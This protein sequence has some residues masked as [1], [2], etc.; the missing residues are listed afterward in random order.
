VSAADWLTVARLALAASLWPLALS[1]HVQAA[2]VGLLLAGFTDAL[3]GRLARRCG[4]ASRR[5]A[6][7]DALADAAVM[8]SVAALLAFLHPALLRDAGALIGLTA[9]VYLI[10]TVMSWIVSR[11]LVDPA[12]LSGKL[13]GGMLYV[14][15]LLT[16]ASG[17]GE[18]LFLVIALG[19]LL[20][21]SAET[22]LRAIRTIQVRA[23]A[24]RARS[25]APQAANGV[26]S[27]KAAAASIA[28]S[29]APATRQMTP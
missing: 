18:A 27:S 14:F 6:R 15:A 2:A 16:L 23:V 12:Q 7:L 4:V 8:V 11:R 3:D 22:L 20:V 29:A 26:A 24:R 13:A 9:A 28:T 17:I 25:H 1:G 19:T 21:A 5:G 10:A